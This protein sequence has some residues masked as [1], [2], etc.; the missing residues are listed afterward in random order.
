VLALG[1]QAGAIDGK[2][3][4]S[5]RLDGIVQVTG[6][7]FMSLEDE[8]GI[9]NAI[10]TPDLLQK[11]RVLLISER[12][13]MIEGILQNQDNVIHIRAEKVSS[14]SVTRAETMSHDFH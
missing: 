9:V 14:L 10:F 1:T 4:E 8:T 5:S 2:F 13:L 12:F 6:L 11:N 3:Q 7:M